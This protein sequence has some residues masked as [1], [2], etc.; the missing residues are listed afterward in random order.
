VPRWVCLIVGARSFN[1]DTA[2]V[3]RPPIYRPP[4]DHLVQGAAQGH[5]DRP[6]AARCR[7]QDNAG[8]GVS[9]SPAGGSVVQKISLG[10]S[11]RRTPFSL[12]DQEQRLNE[13]PRS[14]IRHL[15]F[16]A[17]AID[18]IAE[19]LGVEVQIAPFRLPGG[20]VFQLLVPG[21][22]LRPAAMMT[23]WPSIRR[24]DAIGGGATVVFT[25]IATVD[26]VADLE[27]QFR[28][29]SREYL[30]VARGGKI[31]VRA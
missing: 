26:L 6:I 28:R 18:L 21:G 20:T 5:V 17:Q 27:V 31:I 10:E 9:R 11:L 22:D 15:P 30:I 8:D 4:I 23:L 29:T 7:N 16:D 12:M 19:T 1:A 2:S 3:Y 14:R 25:E 13:R 24:V